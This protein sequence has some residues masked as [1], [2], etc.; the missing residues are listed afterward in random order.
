MKMGQEY[1]RE[2]HERGRELHRKAQITTLE[3]DQHDLRFEKLMMARLIAA[4]TLVRDQHTED[5]ESGIAWFE[6]GL[7]RIGID[8]S[9]YAGTEEETKVA[10]VRELE[11]QLS[12]RYDTEIERIKLEV[13]RRMP[14]IKA[15]KR[16][17]DVARRERERRRRKILVEQQQTQVLVDQRKEQ[18]EH[19]LLFR[20]EAAQ[21]R[22]DMQ[23]HLLLFREEAAQHRTDM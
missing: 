12:E 17:Q 5:C 3:R 21:H 4:R 22:T 7:Q 13:L 1:M 18:E 9:E 16:A 8:T 6:Q 19:L 23:E 2:F 14:K 15:N 10:N 11:E 20:E